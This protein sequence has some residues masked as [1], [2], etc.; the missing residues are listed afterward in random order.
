[1]NRVHLHLARLDDHMWRAL[2]E[3]GHDSARRFAVSIHGRRM[4]LLRR[5]AGAVAAALDGGPVPE[6]AGGPPP[7]VVRRAAPGPEAGGVH[8]DGLAAPDLEAPDAEAVWRLVIRAVLS[9]V[10]SDAL[11][12]VDDDYGITRE[13]L[14]ELRA[15]RERR[16]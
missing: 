13:L 6:S 2:V 10:K 7:V 9:T 14:R 15:P 11:H 8:V 4:P 3:A 5:V 1:M 16:R 12:Y